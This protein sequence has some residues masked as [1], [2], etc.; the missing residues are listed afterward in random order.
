VRQAEA[1][2]SLNRPKAPGAIL[3]ELE[4]ASALVAV[5]PGIGARATNSRLHGVRRLHLARISYDLYYRVA[6]EPLR[7]QILALWHASR[8]TQPP[9]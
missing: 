2:W 1:W 6:E 9:I 7:L 5:Q 8:G 3:S 4:R